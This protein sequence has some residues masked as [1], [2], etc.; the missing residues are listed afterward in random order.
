MRKSELFVYDLETTITDTPQIYAYGV[1]FEDGTYEDGIR[2]ENFIHL[3]ESLNFDS[4]GYA[5]NGSKFDAHF[6]KDLLTKM[7]YKQKIFDSRVLEM[8]KSS[9]YKNEYT[10][11]DDYDRLLNPREYSLL[12]DGNHKILE[13]RI[14]LP[15][16]KYTKGKKKHRVVRLRDS[17]LIFGGSIKSIGETLNK[18]FNTDIYSKGEGDTGIGYDRTEL[19]ETY[20]DFENDGNEKEYLKQDCFIDLTYLKLM[21]TKLNFNDWKLT[22][23]STA[24]HQWMKMFGEDI[25]NEMV[26]DG[27]LEKVN[28]KG[29]IKDFYK[30]RYKGQDKLYS[31]TKLRK[32]LISKILP[33]KWLNEQ[34][35][36]GT[37]MFNIMYKFYRG[38]LAHMN[39]NYVGI[40]IPVGNI[41]V[42]DII[43]SYP[44][45]MTS[46]K[47][48]PIGRPVEGDGGKD[49]PIKFYKVVITKTTT[50]KTGLPF[51]PTLNEKSLSYEYRDTL[52]PGQYFY[53]IDY[54]YERFLKYYKGKH[55]ATI[56]YSFKAL[57]GKKIFG[58]Y[59]DKYFEMK[60]SSKLNGDKGEETIAKLFLNS[61][62]GK[63]AT[64]NCRTSRVWNDKD[65]IWEI[66]ESM[67]ESKFYLPIAI[68]ITAYARMKLVDAVQNDYKYYL[69]GDTDS[70]FVLGYKIINNL[71]LSKKIGD[72]ELEYKGLGGMVI[73]PKQ[74]AFADEDNKIIKL[75]LA[76]INLNRQD[77]SKDE[78]ETYLD[79]LS[80][81]DLVL[82]KSIENQLKPVR[83]LGYG[84]RLEEVIKDIKPI[85]D[86]LPLYN[87]WFKNSKEYAER[88][89]SQR[90]KIIKII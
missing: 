31:T 42:A 84:I 78:F 66:E 83:H 63:F 57:T 48:F 2:G 79:G 73:R 20:Q 67:I 75:G 46:E 44:S 3:L 1:M 29:D 72:W 5:R 28:P 61:V 43:S 16:F 39:P 70:V 32:S 10:I 51:L 38:G 65:L 9:E 13:I 89:E 8:I 41:N 53:M 90:E 86:K 45:E 14:G 60:S 49:Y 64:K 21:K 55:T 27:T 68:C 6:I 81:D 30:L 52:N 54:E 17:N 33:T 22:S 37:Y 62:Y 80:V 88:Y 4:I 47:L 18:H 69:G 15:A 7:G 71:T 24:Y 26:K 82:G 11:Y 35:E 87:Q 77:K 19:Y 50:N 59:I 25:Q 34:N 58:S 12:T 85:W 36:N 76:G 56:E 23:A 40:K 74:Y